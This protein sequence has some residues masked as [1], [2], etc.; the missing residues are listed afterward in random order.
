[1]WQMTV[2]RSDRQILGGLGSFDVKVSAVADVPPGWQ[3][4]NWL[5]ST[6]RRG[7]DLEFTTSCLETGHLSL[8]FRSLACHV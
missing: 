3:N 7:H 6:V 2:D 5:D 8:P 1:M 4:S